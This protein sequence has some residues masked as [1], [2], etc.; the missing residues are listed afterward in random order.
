MMSPVM[1]L[2]HHRWRRGW[3]RWHTMSGTFSISANYLLIYWS[4]CAWGQVND[5]CVCAGHRVRGDRNQTVP[6]HV[7][8]TRMCALFERNPHLGLRGVLCAHWPGQLTIFFR[9]SLRQRGSGKALQRLC[10]LN[11]TPE[12]ESGG[13]WRK[14]A[15]R[16]WNRM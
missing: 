10:C 5:H 15:S 3:G 11:L 8:V 12:G 7:L 14:R 9:C 4:T 16:K 2:N 13:P 1:C 6:R